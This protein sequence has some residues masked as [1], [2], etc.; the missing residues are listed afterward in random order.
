LR[1]IELTGPYMH[2][3]RFET[4]EQVIDF[5]SEGLN[6]SETV[7]PLMKSVHLGGK[8]LSPQDKS[9]LLAF[10]KTLTDTTYLTNPALSSPF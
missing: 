3:G 2:D 4:L 10:L 6:M 8:H 5:Y 1:N 7:D 9:D